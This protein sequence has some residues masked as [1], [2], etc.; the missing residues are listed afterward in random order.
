MLLRFCILIYVIT[1]AFL[2]VLPL[3]LRVWFLDQTNWWKYSH[4]PFIT[5]ISKF[6]AIVCWLVWMGIDT[7]NLI[8]I[9]TVIAF[10]WATI[11]LMI[12]NGIRVVG[13]EASKVCRLHFYQLLE[14]FKSYII[15]RQYQ[16]H[17]IPE[18]VVDSEY[19]QMPSPS[20]SSTPAYYTSS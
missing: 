1:I 8:C 9:F 14:G 13:L 20:T 6:N 19:L 5:N 11:N 10:V 17:I 16:E 18:E 2:E 3:L 4:E 7:F 12:K 15:G